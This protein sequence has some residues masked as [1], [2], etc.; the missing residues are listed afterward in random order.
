MALGRFVECRGD[1]LPADLLT[2]VRD[3]FGSFVDEEHDEVDVGPVGRD[4]VRHLLKDRRLSG[5]RGRDDQSSLA[6]SDRGDEIHD[7]HRDSQFVVGHLEAESLLRIA[8]LEFIELAALL[9]VLWVEPVEGV[10]L[11][12]CDVLLA[13]TGRA[14]LACERV[15]S[16]QV[17]SLDLP[18]TD[19]H[20]VRAAHVAPH[21][22]AQE[23]VTLGEDLEHTFA[24]E[25]LP[26]LEQRMLDLEDKILLAESMVLAEVQ[27]LSQIM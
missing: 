27:S 2:H 21:L 4:G 14:H 3:L 19:V 5:L 13:L 11:L 26:L 15:A 20:V 8:G 9:R 7:A 12:D 24:R 22:G 6:F 1:D 10:D 23:A 17:E 16:P 18:R 25:G